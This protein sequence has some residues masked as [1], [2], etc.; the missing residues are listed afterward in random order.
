MTEITQLF[1]DDKTT[2]VRQSGSHFSP[3]LSPSMTPPN[4][5][6]LPVEA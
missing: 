3:P 4:I 1:S 5:A 2:D 6:L